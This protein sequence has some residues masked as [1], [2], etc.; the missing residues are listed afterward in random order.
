MVGGWLVRGGH[1]KKK[2]KLRRRRFLLAASDDREVS[3]NSDNVVTM[4]YV[5]NI[6][7]GRVLTVLRLEKPVSFD[8]FFNHLRVYAMSFLT[9]GSNGRKPG[10]SSLPFVADTA[11][12]DRWP[13]LAEYLFLT[14][15]PDGSKRQPASLLLM[16][17][18]CLWTA[19]L[20]DRDQARVLW[21]SGE[22]T[23]EIF[24][25]LD[26]MLRSDHVPWRAD[27][28]VMPKK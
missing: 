9:K 20:N 27:R 17:S 19:C 8:R 6:W 28:K 5:T 23:I 13:A 18:D 16:P 21:C 24:G 10:C 15:Y 4:L 1:G 22:S 3:V 12:V 25:L 11:F 7:S 26:E 14:E 2:R